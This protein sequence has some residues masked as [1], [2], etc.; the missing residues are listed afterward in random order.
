MEFAAEDEPQGTHNNIQT[1]ADIGAAFGCMAM[2][3][4]CSDAEGNPVLAGGGAYE[5]TM[6]QIAGM[7]S[8]PPGVKTSYWAMDVLNNFGVVTP[9]YAQ[10]GGFGFN[11]L[12]PVLQIWKA[13]RN[14]AYFAYIVIFMSMGIL[15]TVRA[16]LNPQV[17][18]NIQ[19]ALPKLI[20]T[21]VLITLSYAIAGL[22]VDLMYTSILLAIGLFQTF[23]ILQ[24][25]TLEYQRML[26]GENIFSIAFK[27]IFGT[28]NAAGQAAKSIANILT[29]ITGS[30]SHSGN[31]SLGGIANELL[32]SFSSVIG[33]IIIAFALLLGAVRI[34]LMLMFA[35]V[36][37]IAAVIFAP[38]QILFNALPGSSAF[39]SWLKGLIADASVFPAVAILLL[40]SISLL[41]A[42][43]ANTGNDFQIA[44]GVGFDGSS[45]SPSGFVPPFIGSSS[46]PEQN[47][48]SF[49]GIFG[50]GFLL[51]IPSVAGQIKQAIKVAPNNLQ[52]GAFSSLGPGI[53]AT[54]GVTKWGFNESMRRRAMKNQSGQ[55]TGGLEKALKSQSEQK[56]G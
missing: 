33:Y 38:L 15:I 4:G 34:W 43:N 47:M 36:G 24:G 20:I 49:L 53:A 25:T 30:Q 19:T 39:N 13:F 46:H 35:Y 27:N 17:V 7:L 40:V 50:I 52:A 6:T 45:T 5:D 21:L 29:S 16:K 9:A 37:I 23:G 54:T 32:F 28:G 42:R 56:S 10:G 44:D 48:N 1:G 22:V 55:I 26:M 3:A 31:F 18:I 12:K 8:Q 11:A 14:I 51:A 41:G 2:S